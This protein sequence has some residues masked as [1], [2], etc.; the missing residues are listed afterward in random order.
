M[1][2]ERQERRSLGGAS[3]LGS[4]ELDPRVLERVARGTRP[5]RRDAVAK[6]GIIAAVFALLGHVALTSPA[7]ACAGGAPALVWTILGAA[8]AIYALFIIYHAVRYRPAAAA[9][10]AELPSLTV[11]VPAFNEGPMVQTAL[12]S[13]LEA[14]YPRDRLEILAVD[15][16]STD[17]TW[18]YV[19][20]VAR[21]F[22][23][24]VTAVRMARNGGK[25]DALR[26][27]FARARGE[28]VIT[29]DSDSRLSPDALRQ[30]TAPLIA[31]A[32]VAAVAG[33]VLVLNRY[34]SVLTRLLTAR[35]FVTFDL[36]RAVQSRF[37]A[38]LCCPGALTAYR[39]SAVLDVLKAWSTQTFL[40][41]PCTIG[42]DR[43]LTTWLLRRGHRTVYQSTALVE[44]LVPPTIR[45]VTKMLLRWERGNVR[46]S[47]VMLPTLLTPW[48]KTDRWWPTL[49]IVLDTAQYPAALVMLALAIRHF[50]TAPMDLLRALAAVAVIGL[51][52]SLY[53]LRSERSTDLVYNVGYAVF[54]FIGL[55]WI[56][57]YS[58]LT[59][60]N[61][62]WLTR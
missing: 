35:F 42:E 9:P 28:L 12:L 43:A 57:P 45:G 47:L 49:E 24:R 3:E 44:T 36:G 60:H 17:D 1:K 27:G 34:E 23:D 13:T 30:I 40:G 41:A 33:K 55:Q 56:F 29:V 16:G 53:C 59:M 62:K 37:G 61:G 20:A 39:R 50:L 15:D 31:D 25:R 52:Q 19:D 8:S 14:D 2:E 6:I 26:E 32:R 46:E 11:I 7:S 21:A 22:P 18:S 4:F 51:A 48:R 38:V 58:F 5:T 54:A 10:D